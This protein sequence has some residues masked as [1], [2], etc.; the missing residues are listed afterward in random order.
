M[1]NSQIITLIAALGGLVT[2]IGGVIVNIVVALR[3]SAK[4]EEIS[5]KSDVIIGHVNSASTIASAKIDALT[6]EVADLKAVAATNK[7]TASLLAQS[8]AVEKK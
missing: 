5:A 4:A 3:T 6:K 8:V 1:D 2:I 7:E